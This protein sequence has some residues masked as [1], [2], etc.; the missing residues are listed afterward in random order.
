MNNRNREPIKH[1]N[2]EISKYKRSKTKMNS[3][4]RK[5]KKRKGRLKVKR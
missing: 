3:K 4:N 2:N 1:C 5:I